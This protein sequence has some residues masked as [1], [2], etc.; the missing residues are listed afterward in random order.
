MN[1]VCFVLLSLLSLL[2]VSL[3]I[4]FLSLFF[5]FCFKQF[6]FFSFFFWIFENIVDVFIHIVILILKP[7][8]W[9]LLKL[10]SSKFVRFPISIGIFPFHFIS[11]H[12]LQINKIIFKYSISF[13]FLFSF[14]NLKVDNYHS[15]PNIVNLRDFQFLLE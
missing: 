3:P 14:P 12:I 8:S 10:N 7:E 1:I 5:L 13:S 6:F 9:F 2:S 15:N 11:F 4:F